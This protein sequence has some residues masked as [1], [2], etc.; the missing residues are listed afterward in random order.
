VRC[1]AAPVRD[2]SG[3]ARAALCV[4]GPKDNLSPK[5][6]PRVQH[7]LLTVAAALS[8]RLGFKPQ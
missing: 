4:V 7:N 3:E 2:Y 5:H 6:M 1:L 8:A